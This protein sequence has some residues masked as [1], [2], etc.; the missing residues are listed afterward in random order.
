MSSDVMG[1][2][3]ELSIHGEARG[4]CVCDGVGCECIMRVGEHEGWPDGDACDEGPAT[5]KGISFAGRGESGI[6]C[7]VSRA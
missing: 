2:D 1:S 7:Q 6:V 5:S 3:V 4:V